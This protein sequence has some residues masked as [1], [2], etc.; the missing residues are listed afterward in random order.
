STGTAMQCY[1]QYGQCKLR[2]GVEFLSFRVFPFV[3]LPSASRVGLGSASQV[4]YRITS[5]FHWF[6]WLYSRFPLLDRYFRALRIHFHS[7]SCWSIFR[8]AT[9]PHSN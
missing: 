3:S 4:G 5:R 1:H 6:H 8:A 9:Q 7:V 2:R